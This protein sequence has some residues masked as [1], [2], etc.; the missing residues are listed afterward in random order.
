LCWL[1]A[2]TAALATFVSSV[3]AFFFVSFSA[4]VS[5]ASSVAVPAAVL[6]GASMLLLTLCVDGSLTQTVG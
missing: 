1:L 6:A 2:G 3:T 4:A 5:F